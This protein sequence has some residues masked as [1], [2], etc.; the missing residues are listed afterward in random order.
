MGY[1]DKPGVAIPDH[2]TE[3]GAKALAQRLADYWE[4]IAPRKPVRFEI[5]PVYKCGPPPPGAPNA[6]AVISNLID[7]LPP[8]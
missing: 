3:A 2:D 8:P 5:R 4:K 6:W 1:W 7:G